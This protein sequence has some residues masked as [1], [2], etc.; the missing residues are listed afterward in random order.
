MLE[1]MAKAAENPRSRLRWLVLSRFG[2]VPFSP[3]GRRISDREIMLCAM[4][5]LMDRNS[6]G[7]AEFNPDFDRERFERLGGGA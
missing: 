4:N 7:G 6:G 5:L 1:K 2:I 3:P